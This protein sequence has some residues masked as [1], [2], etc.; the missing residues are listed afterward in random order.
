MSANDKQP[1]PIVNDTTPIWDLVIEDFL[2]TKKVQ[3]DF[4]DDVVADMMQRDNDGVA[5]Y[6]TH[7]QMYN[8]RDCMKDAIQE[9]YDC[10][11]YLR[12]GIAE[13]W[14]SLLD[15][16]YGQTAVA[17]YM[18]CV[19]SNSRI[20]NACDIKKFIDFSYY[21]NLNNKTTAIR[22]TIASLLYCY[23][24]QFEA[25]ETMKKMLM[26]RDNK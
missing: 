22:D 6:H 21:L 11:V 4:V 8:G 3:S 12:Q 10:L 9:I 23:G 24:L 5:K 1:Q 14:D 13:Q 20:C 17:F 25:T 2:S 18:K 7:L 19:N 15:Y 26:Q 16:D